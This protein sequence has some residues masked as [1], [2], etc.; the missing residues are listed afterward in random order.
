MI[1]REIYPEKR[2]KSKNQ[3]EAIVSKEKEETKRREEQNVERRMNYL[4]PE[5]KDD[6]RRKR[7]ANSKPAGGQ[8]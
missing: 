3:Q 1:E 5:V 4:E 6:V 8:T 7:E 2:N